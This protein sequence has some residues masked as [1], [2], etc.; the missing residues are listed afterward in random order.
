VSG[1]DFP[2]AVKARRPGDPPVLVA[3]AERARRELGWSPRFAD[4]DAIVRTA[5]EWM[6]RHPGGY[7]G[8]GAG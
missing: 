4:L 6:R 2:V 8:G 5:F 7:A 1:A 3:A